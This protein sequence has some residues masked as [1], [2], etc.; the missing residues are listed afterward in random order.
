M[1]SR[2]SRFLFQNKYWI[3]CI[4]CTGAIRVVSQKFKP[5]DDRYAHFVDGPYYSHERIESA[6]RFWTSPIP[7]HEERDTTEV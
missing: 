6:V 1:F 2:L 5:K 4:N 3:I 7:E